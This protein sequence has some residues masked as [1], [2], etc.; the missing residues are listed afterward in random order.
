MQRPSRAK[1]PKCKKPWPA[2]P[3]TDLKE[4]CC[5]MGIVRAYTASISLC[6]C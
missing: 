1:A 6:L 2:H 4:V 5:D 3:D